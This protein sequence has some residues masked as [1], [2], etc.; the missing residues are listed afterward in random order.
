MNLKDKVAF[1]TGGASGAGLGQAILLGKKGCKIAIADN[2]DE[3][4][5]LAQ[6]RL[7]QLDIE[8]IVIKLDVTDRDNF[9]LAAI[10]CEKKLGP[11]TLLFNTAGACIFGQISKSS[12]DDF[13]W[14]MDVNL[15]GVINSLVTFLPRMVQDSQTKYIINTASAGALLGSPLAG[16]YCAAKSA[17][18]GLTESLHLEMS[19]FNPHIHVHCILP[20]AINSNIANSIQYRPDKYTHC[21]TS[22]NKA[23][24]DSLT[25]L[26]QKG[27]SPD[28]LAME[29]LDAIEKNHF[30]ICPYPELRDS[31][32]NRF[33]EI[34]KNIPALNP[35][36]KDAQQRL[37]AFAQYRQEMMDI[38]N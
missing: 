18:L 29:S 9:K 27:K 36:D 2:N 15:G 20:A 26:Y 19:L 13:D 8:Y 37:D 21:A 17:V 23:M 4:I 1:I 32:E 3:N 11:V 35:D 12:Y 6:N 24:I 31:L 38:M 34:L 22:M 5:C 16:I 33:T 14:I 30:Y 7:E 10:E 25:T 28:S